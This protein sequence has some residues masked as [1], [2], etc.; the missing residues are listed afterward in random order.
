MTSETDLLRE[1]AE[2]FH[3]TVV[4]NTYQ[5]VTLHLDA[6]H[7]LSIRLMNSSDKSWLFKDLEERRL[8]AL[9]AAFAVR[10]EP[11][12]WR[13]RWKDQLEV[14]GWCLSEDD[15]RPGSTPTRMERFDIVQPLYTSPVQTREDGIRE[16]LK[17]A[18][19]FKA[20]DQLLPLCNADMNAGAKRGMYEAAE[21]IAEA[22]E[23]LLSQPEPKGDKT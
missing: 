22:I 2:S 16:A 20:R 12:A 11:V 15:P 8:A 7:A 6:P 3:V 5:D 14:D 1:F 10:S 17:V 9:S 21:E 19:N 4:D 18:E 23:A 13:W